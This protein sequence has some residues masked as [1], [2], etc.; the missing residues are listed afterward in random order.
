MTSLTD[1]TRSLINTRLLDTMQLSN[2]AV[3]ML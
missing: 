3:D 2:Y 1:D